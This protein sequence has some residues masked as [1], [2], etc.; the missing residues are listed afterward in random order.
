MLYISQISLLIAS[1]QQVILPLDFQSLKFHSLQSQYPVQLLITSLALIFKLGI[2]IRTFCIEFELQNG[3]SEKFQ[4]LVELRLVKLIR[5][6]E[7]VFNVPPMVIKMG[8]SEFHPV[9]V[10]SMPLYKII[11]YLRKNYRSIDS[12]IAQS[13]TLLLYRRQ[14][15]QLELKMVEQFQGEIEILGLEDLADNLQNLVHK[16]QQQFMFEGLKIA[17]KYVNCQSLLQVVHQNF[18]NRLKSVADGML[19]YAVLQGGY[20]PRHSILKSGLGKMIDFTGRIFPFW[21]IK[22]V[23]KLKLPLTV[24]FNYL[25]P[26]A[27]GVS[28]YFQR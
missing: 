14:L 7:K 13:P 18:T 27:F 11:N 20:Y 9:K 28:N 2:P 15:Y 5:E 4:K 3:E 21:L 16:Y 12:Q 17:P 24:T 22:L 19:A 26:D 6:V 25:S 23:R 10:V 8:K 1:T